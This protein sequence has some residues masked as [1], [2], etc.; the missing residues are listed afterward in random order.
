MC[1]LIFS[2]LSIRARR[3]SSVVIW[4]L[5]SFACLLAQRSCWV[6][7]SHLA[8]NSGSEGYD[9]NTFIPLLDWPIVA[10]V[11]LFLTLLVIAIHRRTS[12]MKSWDDGYEK[13]SGSWKKGYEHARKSK[14]HK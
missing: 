2:F 10:G 4:S 5:L 3:I 9:E 13:V 8:I 11:V 12:P 7:A 14:G 1:A 6:T